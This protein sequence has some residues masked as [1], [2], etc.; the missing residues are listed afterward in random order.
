M[1]KII[2]FKN[3]ENIVK[4]YGFELVE[5]KFKLTRSIT[6]QPQMIIINGQPVKNEPQVLTRN[7]YIWF[8]DGTIFNDNIED[9]TN[10]KWMW[11]E[12]YTDDKLEF[13]DVISMYEDDTDAMKDYMSHIL[14]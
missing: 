8:E 12:I 9:G 10:F 14:Q 1:I 5:D 7:Y 6:T 13:F 4:E 11:V 2:D 3:M